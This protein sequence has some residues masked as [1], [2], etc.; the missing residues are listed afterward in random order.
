MRCRKCWVQMGDGESNGLLA[1]FQS[2]RRSA[3]K[4]VEKRG[5]LVARKV[6]QAI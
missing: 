6:A 4:F 2:T 5:G 1:T 3:F